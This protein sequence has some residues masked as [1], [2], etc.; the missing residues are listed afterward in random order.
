MTM[1]KTELKAAGVNMD[2]I[3]LH[4][5][6]TN[7]AWCR[8]HG[9]AFV[10]NPGSCSCPR[11]L[12]TGNTTDGEVNTLLNWIRQFLHELVK[13]WDC[14]FFIP[15]LSW[16]EVQLILTAKEPCITTTSCLLAS[17]P[18]SGFKPEIH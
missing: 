8:D 15:V 16:K 17:Q 6:P 4:L 5:L 2:N 9:P 18:E 3:T 13:S 7:D 12:S 14:L 10:I 1:W 11:P